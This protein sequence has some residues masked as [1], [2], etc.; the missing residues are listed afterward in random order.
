M[1]LKW[2]EA[3]QE[4]KFEAI[5]LQWRVL[6]IGLGLEEAST[7]PC[8]TLR[9]EI[10]REANRAASCCLPESWGMPHAS[11]RP[12]ARLRPTPIG[13]VVCTFAVLQTKL[14][15]RMNRQRAAACF[16]RPESFPSAVACRVLAFDTMEIV[17]GCFGVDHER[18][19]LVL[20]ST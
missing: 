15:V 14:Q 19:W 20:S 5:H 1:P 9:L 8:C 4:R 16:S 6:V 3:R 10:P 11:D 12:L 18:T 17:S 2:N 13:T 7:N